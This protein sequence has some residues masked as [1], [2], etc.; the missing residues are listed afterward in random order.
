MALTSLIKANYSSSDERSSHGPTVPSRAVDLV[1][2]VVL[3]RPGRSKH[4]AVFEVDS[5]C[6]N[7]NRN[8]NSEFSHPFFTH[9]VNWS[10]VIEASPWPLGVAPRQSRDTSLPGASR[11]LWMLWYTTGPSLNHVYPLGPTDWPV[12]SAENRCAETVM[13]PQRA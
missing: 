5:T 7:S 6:M 12:N 11:R 2:D 9:T 10:A 13:P 1:A 3:R 4:R 8:A